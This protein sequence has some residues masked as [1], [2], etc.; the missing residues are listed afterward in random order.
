MSERITPE[1]LETPKPPEN[2]LREDYRKKLLEGDQKTLLD[3]IDYFVVDRQDKWEKY[4][5]NNFDDSEL[6]E[7]F[8]RFYV[9]SEENYEEIY[10]EGDRIINITNLLYSITSEK[11]PFFKTFAHDVD[12]GDP[13]QKA[14]AL[15]DFHKA[16]TDIDE[17]LDNEVQTKRVID[18]KGIP[19]YMMQY[20][21]MRHG[22]LEDDQSPN[23][24]EI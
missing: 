22:Q 21:K 10:L 4:K 5:Q 19:W 13:A 24:P 18:K 8:M 15:C 6:D 20:H 3:A 23:Q 7:H 9:E 12:E 16:L 17:V 1:P 11:Y 2:V 14:Q